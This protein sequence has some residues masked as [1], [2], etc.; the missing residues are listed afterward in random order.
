MKAGKKPFSQAIQIFF[1]DLK[2]N[3]STVISAVSI[4]GFFIFYFIPS[5]RKPEYYGPFIFFAA[6][7]I[8]ATL[9]EIKVKLYEAGRKRMYSSLNEARQTIISDIK[10]KIEGKRDI[11][12]N[13]IS[14]KASETLPI[15]QTIIDDILTDQIVVSSNV[16]FNFYCVNPGFLAAVDSSVLFSDKFSY[17]EDKRRI[18]DYKQNIDFIKTTIRNSN[19]NLLNKKVTTNLILYNA[20]PNFYAFVIGSRTIYWGK[21]HWS[22]K[23]EFAGSYNTCFY[24]TIDNDQNFTDL[25]KMFTS[26]VS[27]LKDSG[28][29]RINMLDDA[30]LYNAK[31]IS[32]INKIAYDNLVDDYVERKKKYK[33]F[34]KS[35]DT[36]RDQIEELY[37]DID[38][39]ILKQIPNI[40]GILE[41]GPGAGYLTELFCA[42]KHKLSCIEISDSISAYIR[43]TIPE[44][45]LIH[46]DFLTHHFSGLY[47]VVIAISFIHLYPSSSTPEILRRIY[48]LLKQGGYAY[49]FTSLHTISRE[50]YYRKD[51]EDSNVIIRYRKEFTKG[52]LELDLIAANFKIIHY[53]ERKD[54]LYID[55]TWMGF[56]VQKV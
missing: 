1:L 12:I 10:R 13:I 29:M 23:K 30:V 42:N 14:Y 21:F 51:N 38:T 3:W 11:E 20:F 7:A 53:H 40:N 5:L 36:G 8:I 9:L 54:G 32:A 56:F 52:E 39:H 28:R 27:F 44:V 2:K 31:H 19:I 45:H 33:E 17:K 25:F 46:N 50:G 48:S 43:S 35:A 26:E 18:D 37:N 6:S 15:Y 49:I 4:L 41:I 34:T 24:S 16:I 55:R 47:D 22:D